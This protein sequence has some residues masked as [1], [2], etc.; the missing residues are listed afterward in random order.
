[1]EHFG[2]SRGEAEKFWE[3]NIWVQLHH[4]AKRNTEIYRYVFGCYPDDK[5]K[6]LAD[7]TVFEKKTA[8]DKMVRYK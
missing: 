8:N 3:E 4:I 2:I 6:K 5:M 7:I 1:M